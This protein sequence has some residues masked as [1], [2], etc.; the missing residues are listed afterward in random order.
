MSLPSNP[1]WARVSHQSNFLREEDTNSGPVRKKANDPDIV[2]ESSV[3]SLKDP[4]STLRISIPCR[5][6]V[7]THN[8]C[9]DAESFLQL[10]EQAPTWQ[11]PICNKTVSFEALAV[12]EYVQEILARVPRGTDQVTI[13]PDGQW[14]NEKDTLP[15][16]NRNGYDDYDDSE[17]DLVE[18]SDFRVTQIKSE[19]VPTPQSLFAKTPPLPS[20]EASSAPRTGNKRT[21]DVIDLTLSDEDEPPRPTKKVAYNSLSDPSRRYHLPS[22]GTSPIPMHPQ[23]QT[24]HSSSSGLRMDP[25]PSSHNRH[26]YGGYHQP[27]QRPY[28]GQGSSSYPTYIGS[29]P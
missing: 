2:V 25:P 22:F 11:C 26:S 10:Q 13:E 7:C 17:D 24:H 6:M 23:A 9:F 28:P 1:C 21:S 15:K 5:S 18:I 29:S 16:P 3:M 20:R 27:P 14:S 12:D 4:I 19:A 8:Q